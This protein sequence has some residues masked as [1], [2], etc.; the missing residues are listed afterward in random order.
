M[1]ITLLIAL[2]LFVGLIVCWVLLPAT[3]ITE[4]TAAVSEGELLPLQSAPQA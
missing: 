2:A 4:S 3:A 1:D